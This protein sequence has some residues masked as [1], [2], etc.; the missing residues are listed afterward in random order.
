MNVL[1]CAA[2]GRRLTE[3]V[4]R[5]DAVPEPPPYEGGAAPDGLYR[6]P[7]TLPRGAYCI[8][9]APFGA[10]YVQPSGAGEWD[11]CIADGPRGTMVLNP[12]DVL[13]LEPHPVPRR[14]VGCCGPAGRDGVN[15]LCTCGAEVAILSADCYTSYELRFVPDA[16]RVEPAV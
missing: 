4:R 6:A 7:A 12:D 10:P 5:L 11:P 13:D 2:C 16:V 15:R 3:P 14:N 8:D 9:E 1:H